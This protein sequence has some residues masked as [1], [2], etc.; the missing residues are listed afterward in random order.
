LQA[1]EIRKALDVSKE[2]HMKRRSS[3]EDYEQ[4]SSDAQFKERMQN[5]FYLHTE[6]CGVACVL[7]F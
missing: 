2:D 6:S 4:S 7:G 3:F 1:D 5:K